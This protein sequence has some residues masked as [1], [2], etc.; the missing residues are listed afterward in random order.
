MYDF[1]DLHIDNLKQDILNYIE[2]S[3]GTQLDEERFKAKIHEFYSRRVNNTSLN[4]NLRNRIFVFHGGCL[5]CTN[6]KITGSFRKCLG[7]KFFEYNWNLP[8]K[9]NGEV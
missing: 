4:L 2:Q 7:C 8:N 9:S 6:Q 1:S 5:G 3:D